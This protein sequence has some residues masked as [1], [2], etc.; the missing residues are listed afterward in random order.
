MSFQRS[1]PARPAPLDI[2]G[3]EFARAGHWLID[4]AASVL[5][6][7]RERPVTRVDW[8]GLP[9][10]DPLPESGQ[11][12]EALIRET[13]GLLFDYSLYNGHPKFSGYITSSPAPIGALADLLAALVNPNVGAGI[14]SPVATAIEMQTIRWLTE[15]IGL[16]AGFGGLLVSGGNM[17]NIT[18][19]VTVRKIKQSGLKQDQKHP[20]LRIYCSRATHTWIEKAVT[21]TG[22]GMEAIHWIDTHRD[23]TLDCDQLDKAIR[24][25]QALGHWPL[26]VVA[27]AGDVSTG[28]IDD[29]AS[30]AGC[31]RRHQLWFHVDGAYGVPAAALPEWK[32][33][34]AGLDQADSI[35]FDPH[36]WLYTP[37]EAGCVLV[38][39][40]ADLTATFSSHPAYYNFDNTD[41]PDRLNYYEF[42]FQNSRGFRALK[43]WLGLRQAGRTGY[44]RMIRENIRLSQQLFQGAQ[45]SPA[46]EAVSQ[47]LSIACFRFHPHS[48]SARP[49]DEAG[50][51]QLNTELLNQLQREGRVFLSPAV[52]GEKY[53]L[54]SCLVNFRTTEEDIREMI[55][56]IEETGYRV[57]E[58]MQ[59]SLLA[60]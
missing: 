58:K 27:N 50:L 16:P 33:Q 37:L 10:A 45:A 31:C 19:F 57:F 38:K 1:T 13:A 18:A 43:V 30:I 56:I 17:A 53:C 52:V 3:E 20:M 54:R 8:P 59:T 6:S 44:I 42:G 2:T 36:K 55:A 34:F 23:N 46:L 21:L 14:L 25:D 22:M 5:D 47:S 4:E 12:V 60:Q 35:A 51:N 9:T 39:N 15:L 40:P 24:E 32:E 29:L 41:Q 26:M 48:G 11:P 7:I 28:A 49:L